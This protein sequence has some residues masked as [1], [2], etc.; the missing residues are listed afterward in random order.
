MLAVGLAAIILGGVWFQMLV[1]FAAGVMIW[2]LWSMISPDRPV[3]AMLLGI[4]TAV[5]LSTQLDI[6]GPFN[7]NGPIHL[8]FFVAVPLVGAALIKKNRVLFAIF[9]L[10]I[11]IATFALVNFR[12]DLG[13]VWIFWVMLVVIASDTFGYLAGRML[14]GPKFWPK[15]SPKKTWSG[16]IAGWVGAGVV[17]YIFTLFTDAGIGI[18][19]ISMAVALAGQIGDIAESALKRRVGIKDSSDLIPGHGGLLD[20]FDAMLGATLFIVVL[21]YVLRIPGVAF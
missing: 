20:R 7:I 15:V 2:E 17:G 11:L 5:I 18:V 10:A 16:T 21:I 8:A 6:K 1:V 3:P 14:G 12:T 13:F 9:S 4:A 19:L